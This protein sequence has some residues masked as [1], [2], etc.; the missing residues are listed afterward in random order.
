MV[1]ERSN[2][3]D[4]RRQQYKW[5]LFGDT[6]VPSGIDDSVSCLPEDEQFARVKHINFTCDI[7]KAAVSLVPK[8]IIKSVDSLEYFASLSNNLKQGDL[9]LYQ[10][11][12]WVAD[13]EFG[14]QMLNGVNPVVIRRCTTLP[15]NFKVTDDIVKPFLTRGITLNEEM[16]VSIGS[17]TAII[18]LLP[19]IP[20]I[21]IL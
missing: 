13:V 18:I 9:P 10:A 1:R 6:E 11:S 7:L 16:E 8:G 5:A 15:S 2:Q 19:G 3:I 12:R 17:Y 21:T 14:R 4:K 20:G